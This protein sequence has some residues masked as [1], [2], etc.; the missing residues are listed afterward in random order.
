MAQSLHEAAFSAMPDTILAAERMRTAAS[1]TR[2]AAVERRRCES[3]WRRWLTVETGR[4]RP[5]EA[6]MMARLQM[7]CV[8]GVYRSMSADRPVAGGR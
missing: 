8:W 6:R 2:A 4:D 5:R 3:A 7:R 1:P